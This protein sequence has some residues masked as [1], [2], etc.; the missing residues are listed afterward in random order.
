MKSVL[1]SSNRGSLN[2][3]LVAQVR[4]LRGKLSDRELRIEIRRLAGVGRARGDD[5]FRQ[6]FRETA[7]EAEP[8][9]PLKKASVSETGDSVIAESVDPRVHTVDELLK[10]CKVDLTI[11][12]VERFLVNKWE[13]AMAEPATTVGVPESKPGWSAV[14]VAG[15]ILS[16]LEVATSRFMN[17]FS[18]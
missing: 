11:W 15:Y 10:L 14:R 3:E 17:R 12:E 8:P 4:A 5:I 16:G 1:W 2:P 9:P 6:I 13:V 7:T 18:R